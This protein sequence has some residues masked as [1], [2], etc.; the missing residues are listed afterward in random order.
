MVAAPP[1]GSVGDG[2][3]VGVG[4]TGIGVPDGVGVSETGG[5]GGGGGGN[6]ASGERRMACI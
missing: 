3:P 5:S 6:V 2:V 1:A 4:E